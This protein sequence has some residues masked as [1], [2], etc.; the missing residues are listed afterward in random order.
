LTL[1]STDHPGAIVKA[2]LHN[3]I[4]PLLETI[5]QRMSTPIPHLGGDSD[6]SMDIVSPSTTSP[7]SIEKILKSSVLLV[8]TQLCHLFQV[9]GLLDSPL[10]HTRPSHRKAELVQRDFVEKTVEL[11]IDSLLELNF[12]IE[13]ISS[14]TSLSLSLLPLPAVCQLFGHSHANSR[15]RKI[16]ENSPCLLCSI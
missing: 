4:S 5:F 8:A 3:N 16:Q 10:H 11:T 1:L 13:V 9:V 12:P 7:S 2:L 6:S 15:K 14:Q